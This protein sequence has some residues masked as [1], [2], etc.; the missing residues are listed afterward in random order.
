MLERDNER[1]G[2]NLGGIIT[3]LSAT[4]NSKQRTNTKDLNNKDEL[5]VPLE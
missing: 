4:S 3:I 5:I 2:Y 1:Y